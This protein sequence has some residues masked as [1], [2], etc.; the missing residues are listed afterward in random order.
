M[1]SDRSS[2]TCIRPPESD[3]F[4][5]L[6][7]KNLLMSRFSYK[8]VFLDKIVESQ[9]VMEALKLVRFAPSAHNIQPWEFYWIQKKELRKGLI[10]AMGDKWS[11][12]MKK[13]NLDANE[14]S[15]FLES[16]RSTF[17]NAPLFFV[18]SCNFKSI[19]KYPD[20][21]RI[22]TERLLFTQSV[23][24]AICYFLL[25]L[26]FYGIESCWYSAGAFASDVIKKEL[27]L[28][29]YEESQ[30]IICAGYGDLTIGENLLPDRPAK[31]EVEEFI[32]IL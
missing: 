19:Q 18:V 15:R 20:P 12:D 7:G 28:S 16:S 2:Q 29:P 24:N 9:H 22:I 11:I 31:K 10:K 25:G 26:K 3:L 27:H 6:D 21:V 4:R 13:D 32:H 1:V 30:A 8:K 5:H 17:M 23:A 14:I